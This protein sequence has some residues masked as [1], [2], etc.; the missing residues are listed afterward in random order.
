MRDISAL[1]PRSLGAVTDVA[2][3][4]IEGILNVSE[5]S[6]EFLPDGAPADINPKSKAQ[7]AHLNAWTALFE[8][9]CGMSNVVAS[10][11]AVPLLAQYSP[12]INPQ[13]IKNALIS[14]EERRRVETLLEEHGKLSP[15]GLHAAVKKVE[16]C[17]PAERAKIAGRFFADFTRYHRDL[18][19]MEAVVAAMESVNVLGNERFRDRK[20]VV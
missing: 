3:P 17:K 5:D 6:H 14:R 4:R 18:R 9:E 15:A 2:D 7:K 10:Y 8:R 19:R 12:P 1:S 13:Q 20:S 16:G 11:E